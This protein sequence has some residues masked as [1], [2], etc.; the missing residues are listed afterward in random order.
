MTEIRGRI[1]LA[2]SYFLDY[3]TF[4]IL[5]KGKNIYLNLYKVYFVVGNF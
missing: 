5:K 4:R 1:A 2:K 3:W